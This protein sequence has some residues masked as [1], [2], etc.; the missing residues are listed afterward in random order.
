LQHHFFGY[1]IAKLNDLLEKHGYV[2][3]E[4]EYNNVFLAPA[5]LPKAKNTDV[6]TAYREGY[7]D[8]T[9]RREK[10]RSN[11]DMEILQNLNPAETVK[12]LDNFYARHKGK[13]EISAS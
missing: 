1:S 11:H 13:Y 7:A 4:V 2:L 6:L 9:D 10:F 5:E 8:R 3:L 12:F